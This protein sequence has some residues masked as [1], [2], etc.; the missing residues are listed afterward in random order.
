MKTENKVMLHSITNPIL[1]SLSILKLN[2][3]ATD[4]VTITNDITSRKQGDFCCQT[5]NECL[6]K[7]SCCCSERKCHP[8]AIECD[9]PIENT[10]WYISKNDTTDRTPFKKTSNGLLY[11]K[12][13]IIQE[14]YFQKDTQVVGDGHESKILF[15]HPSLRL[16][17]YVI[18]ALCNNSV[19][20]FNSQI[21]IH[22]SEGN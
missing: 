12:T 20:I 14:I 6:E 15:N 7:P 4:S 11:I 19:T 22:G 17:K 5:C 10:K 16:E 21:I 13:S 2:K 1:A 9:T 18:T 3:A 8:I